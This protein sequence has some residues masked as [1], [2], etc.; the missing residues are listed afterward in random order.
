MKK[1]KPFYRPTGENMQN[2][3]ARVVVKRF[4]HMTFEDAR[5]ALEASFQAEM[6]RRHGES[7]ADP[8]PNPSGASWRYLRGV[9]GV[10]R[11]NLGVASSNDRPMPSI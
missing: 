1:R 3:A 11:G 9:K 5:K 2:A 6:R 10:G 4:P 7:E 8:Y